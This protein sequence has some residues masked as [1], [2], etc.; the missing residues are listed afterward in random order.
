MQLTASQVLDVSINAPRV[1]IAAF[2]GKI[3]VRFELIYLVFNVLIMI[4]NG[5]H[6]LL[7]AMSFL[8]CVDQLFLSFADPLCL[9]LWP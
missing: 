3:L 1:P 6:N 4:Y 7:L 2:S 8:G 9:H 5:I